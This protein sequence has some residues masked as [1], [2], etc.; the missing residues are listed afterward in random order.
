MIHQVNWAG[1]A[2]W[3]HV[4]VPMPIFRLAHIFPVLFPV[5]TIHNPVILHKNSN[6]NTSRR[7]AYD[8][9]SPETNP[10]DPMNVNAVRGCY[11]FYASPFLS[12]SFLCFIHWP[13]PLNYP[14][15]P[16]V[17]VIPASIY[18]CPTE[19]HIRDVLHANFNPTEPF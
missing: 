4:C 10:G 7:Q 14:C 1:L 18:F 2:Y 9:L 17:V 15:Y 8:T 6:H 19:F 11:S 12:C 5:T 16:T 3:V 13:V